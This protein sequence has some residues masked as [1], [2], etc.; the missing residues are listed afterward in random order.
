MGNRTIRV[1]L[2]KAG[3]DGHDRGIKLVARRLMD[4]GMEVIYTGLRSTPDQ[5]AAAAAQEDADVLGLS[6]LAGDHMIQVPKVMERLRGRALADIMVVMG[7]IIPPRDIPQ[8]EKMG[9][10][11]VFPPGTPLEHIAQFIETNL[12]PNAEKEHST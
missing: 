10:A 8:L 11:R 2:A 9:V 12:K 3:L 7:G 4:A 5:I 1:L 6:F